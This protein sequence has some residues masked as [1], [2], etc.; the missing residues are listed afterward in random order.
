M[1][2]CPLCYSQCW[3]NG[4]CSACGFW[5]LP[6]PETEPKTEPEPE[7]P[8]RAPARKI[9]MFQVTQ[10]TWVAETEP[11]LWDWVETETWSCT[12]EKFMEL[13]PWAVII[14]DVAEPIK[15][16][17]RQIGYEYDVYFHKNNYYV[18]KKYEGQE[19]VKI[20]ASF[21]EAEKWVDDME[22]F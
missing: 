18:R 5:E 21:K 7:P 13:H 22:N 11:E 6:E 10:D 17:D 3:P 4:Q 14:T 12:Y 9:N 8:T 1:Q 2:M 16:E 20:F 19:L 15:I